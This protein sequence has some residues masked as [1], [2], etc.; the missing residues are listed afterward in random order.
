MSG[1]NIYEFDGK[2][3]ALEIDA[4]TMITNSFISG[5]PQTTGFNNQ[6]IA[7][8]ATTVNT[9][10][11]EG[12]HM[13]YDNVLKRGSIYTMNNAA[14][15]RDIFIGMPSYT[16]GANNVNVSN[17]NL[18][19]S[20]STNGQIKQGGAPI[21]HTTGSANLYF[22]PNT[23]NFTTSGLINVALG[24]ACGASLSLGS[25]NCAVGYDVLSA[26]STGSF[27]VGL[28]A[29]VMNVGNVTGSENVGIGSATLSRITTGQRNVAIGAG[30]GLFLT[31]G[32]FNTLLGAG[33]ANSTTI[34]G[35]E[36]VAIGAAS[37]TFLGTGS[38]NTCVGNGAGRNIA[39]ASLNTA[40]GYLSMFGDAGPTTG[41]EN[42]GIGS[43]ALRNL[44]TGFG[45]TALGGGAA[46][47]ITT[48]SYNTA[49]GYLALSSGALS[50]GA[51]NV[52]LGAYA[53][54]AIG[55]GGNNIAIGF[56]SGASI[57]DGLRNICIGFQSMFGAGAKTGT[58]NIVMGTNSGQALTTGSSNVILSG[59]ASYTT[60]TGNIVIRN[61]GVPGD[62]SVI[63]IGT[64]M[65]QCYISGIT[66]VSAGTTSRTAGVNA[67]GQIGVLTDP[68]S[69]GSGSQ[70]VAIDVTYTTLVVRFGYPG[71]TVRPFF[72]VNV[73]TNAGAGGTVLYR[74]RDDTNA[75][76]IATGSTTSTTPV[77]LALSAVANI[78]AGEAVFSLTAYSLVSTG[79]F[80]SVNLE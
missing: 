46:G 5:N 73:L 31:T 25:F 63:R 51:Q 20:S 76:D 33:V 12:L 60:E 11:G 72:A 75:L 57:S 56:L 9:G 27:N 69:Y 29:N 26:L 38:Q 64:G 78:P 80:Y 8:N 15:L 10:T 21:F 34:T 4:T 19:V 37:L 14:T 44:T 17:L 16:G 47:L 2:I 71:S 41:N 65:S 43:S 40:Y 49:I 39:T 13:G 30:T 77:R 24:V 36:N 50:G 45:N 67:S 18:P 59:G 1:T 54:S 35:S 7:G 42:T 32:N 70:S 28:G 68:I 79:T 53:L 58:D 6:F 52:A 48:G 23:G 62:S 74:L 22:G 66:G 61:G 55:T 3:V